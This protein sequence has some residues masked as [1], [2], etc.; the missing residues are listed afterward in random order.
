MKKKTTKAAKVLAA[1]GLAIGLF[2]TAVPG[3][4]AIGQPQMY[5]P[6]VYGYANQSTAGSHHDIDRKNCNWRGCHW[7]DGGN[8]NTASYFTAAVRGA[9]CGTHRYRHQGQNGDV[10][11]LQLTRSC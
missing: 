5:S 4:E 8:T 2:I 11:A 9:T 1:G 10:N 6:N 7:M 3:A